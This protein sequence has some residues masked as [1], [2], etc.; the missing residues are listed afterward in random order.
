MRAP[1]DLFIW[2]ENDEWWD[3]D[4]ENKQFVLTEKAP[5]KAKISFQKYLKYLEERKKF[6]E[7]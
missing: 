2:Q 7:S 4:E 3:V 1:G 5:E 6:K